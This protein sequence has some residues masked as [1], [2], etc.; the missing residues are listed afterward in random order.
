M[1]YILFRDGWIG[2]VTVERVPLERLHGE[3]VVVDVAAACALDRNYRVTHADL[4]AFERQ[5]SR[6]LASPK[7][8]DGT[9]KPLV[10]DV[11]SR[12]SPFSHRIVLLRT[13]TVIGAMSST[14]RG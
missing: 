1:N 9:A 2:G 7:E 5:H 3:A 4:E 11:S 12:N 6:H 8:H 14:S 10:D 13:G